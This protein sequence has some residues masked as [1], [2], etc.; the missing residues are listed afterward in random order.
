MVYLSIFLNNWRSNV[1]TEKQNTMFKNKSDNAEKMM[2]IK[3]ISDQL[4]RKQRKDIR[5][6]VI[7]FGMTARFLSQRK[8][9]TLKVFNNL[10]NNIESERFKNTFKVFHEDFEEGRRKK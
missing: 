6:S 2:A 1:R 8:K 10:I 3:A 9:F 7:K 4:R 5:D